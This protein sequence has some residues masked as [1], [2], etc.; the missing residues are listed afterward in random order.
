MENFPAL[1]DDAWEWWGA[2]IDESQEGRWVRDDV[3]RAVVADVT[4]APAAFV[5][6]GEAAARGCV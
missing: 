5:A 1:A 6:F 3:E 2:A 4:A